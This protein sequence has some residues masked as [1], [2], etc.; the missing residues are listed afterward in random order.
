M[1]SFQVTIL[2]LVLRFD[3]DPHSEHKQVDPDF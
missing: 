3:T 1:V 2:P